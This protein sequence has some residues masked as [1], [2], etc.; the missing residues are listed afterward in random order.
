V[1]TVLFVQLDQA[2]KIKS[3]AALWTIPGRSSRTQPTPHF[4]GLDVDK[5]T[6]GVAYEAVGSRHNAGIVIKP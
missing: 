6:I 2:F 5:E 3:A 4:V 1:L